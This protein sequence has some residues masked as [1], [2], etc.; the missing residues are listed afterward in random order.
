MLRAAG[1]EPW[2]P[3][4]NCLRSSAEIDIARE[5]GVVAATEW[6]GNSVQVAM[7][8]YLKAT[9]DDFKRASGIG[10][11]LRPV[12]A[13]NEVQPCV[14]ESPS[15][16]RAI[17]QKAENPIKNGLSKKTPK[18]VLWTILDSN[19]RPPRCQRGALTN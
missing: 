15:Q 7:K 17:P 18:P 5:H 3:L 19:Q 13:G 2:A 11:K 14:T 8:H 6:V 16:N 1:I 9:P 12:V 10:T 4:F